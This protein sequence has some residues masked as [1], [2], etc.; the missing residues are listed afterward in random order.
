MSAAFSR[1]VLLFLL[2]GL[3]QILLDSAVFVGLTYLG[4]PLVAGNL[5]GRVCGATLGF[6]LNGRHTF[7]IAGRP[8]LQRIHLLRFVIAWSALTALSTLLLAA[9]DSQFELRGAWIAKPAVEALMA[10]FGFVVSRQW[11]FR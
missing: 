1:Q 2:V 6:W 3:G 5:A 9:V 4:L 8:R 10:V 11:V 7:A